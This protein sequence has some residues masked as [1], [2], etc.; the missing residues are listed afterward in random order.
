MER[1]LVHVNGLEVRP[2]Y[3][4]RAGDIIT[5]TVPAETE[6]LSPEDIPLEILYQDDA[7]MVVNKP[8]GLVVH[9]AAGNMTGTLMNAV[10]HHARRLAE[11]GAPLRPGVVHRLDKDTSGVLV[12]ALQDHAYYNLVKQFSERTIRRRYRALVYGSLKGDSGELSTRIGR[13]DSDRKKMSTKTRHGRE[14][15]TRWRVLERYRGAT[16]VE[17]V[18]GTGRT[19]QIRVHLASIGHPV[20]GDQTYGKKTTIERPGGKLKIARQM[21]HAELLGFVHPVTGDYMEFASEPPEDM[22]EVITLLRTGAGSMPRSHSDV[23][24]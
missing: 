22:K 24:R 6:T 1:G 18:L 7:L 21:L 8:A 4:V 15:L 11:A 13:S 16:L 23:S 9:P 20:L 17:A 14:A 2:N 19:H 10:A 3:R 12:V 5:I